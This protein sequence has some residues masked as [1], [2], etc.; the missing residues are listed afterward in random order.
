MLDSN[1]NWLAHCLEIKELEQV[2]VERSNMHLH[3]ASL[4]LVTDGQSTL[5]INGHEENIIFGQLIAL[6]SGSV[7]QFSKPT[8]LDFSA[9]LISFNVYNIYDM[10]LK[11]A[12]NWGVN[13]ATGYH[14][15]SLSDMVVAHIRSSFNEAITPLNITIKQFILYSL[16]KQLQQ[17]T[18]QQQTDE[19]TLEQRIERTVAYITQNYNAVIA[20]DQLA[21]IA[22]YSPS[23]YSRKFTE[24]YRKTP[25]EYLI[26]YRILRAQERLLLTD[27]LSKNV[28][29]RVGFDDAQ[30]F[31]R[32]FK[33]VVGVPPKHYKKSIASCRIC[34][35]SSAHAEVAIALGVI[36]HSVIISSSLTPSYQRELFLENNVTMLEMPQYVIQQDVILQQQPDFIIGSHL[37]EETKLHFQTITPVITRLPDELNK[38]MVYL[39]Q[40]FNRQSQAQQTM[41]E[42]DKEVKALRDKIH[43]HI[44]SNHNFSNSTN[45]ATTET[46]VLYLRVEELGYRYL[47]E[48]S[49][50]SAILLYKELG[51]NM[52]HNL[53]SYENSFNVCSLQQLEDANPTYLFIEKRIMD[54]YS[55]DHS[56]S[57]LQQS[58]QW[59]N[60]DAVRDQRVFYVDTG[61]W[62]NNCSVFGKREIMKQ[63]EEAILGSESSSRT[64]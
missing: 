18:P 33:E 58:E 35:L 52:P 40:L 37:T 7:I 20:R 21:A 8:H 48:A 53:G 49:T 55:A 59:G 32:Q 46:T 27:D 39:G 17:E 50:D 9:Y 63:I 61:L 41:N 23:Y 36:P 60:L 64:Q 19:A 13:T 51:L 54:Y 38:L 57:K 62:I 11:I 56:L 12:S 4:I 2:L 44:N 30:Y 10:N 31:S 15:R 47:G 28:A 14:I 24:L 45:K 42:L 3:H 1:P 26:R 25:I 6:E 29:K 5:Y 43:K 34:F 16:L 22:G